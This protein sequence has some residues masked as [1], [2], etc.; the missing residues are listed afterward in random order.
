MVDVNLCSQEEEEEEE[1]KWW[2]WW[3]KRRVDQEV[4]SSRSHS[5]WK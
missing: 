3:W 2:K 1:W 5:Y 4:E